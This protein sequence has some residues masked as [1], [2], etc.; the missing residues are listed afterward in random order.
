MLQADM[1]TPKD[2]KEPAQSVFGRR[3]RRYRRTKISGIEC[4]VAAGKSVF[5]GTVEDLSPQGF[6][7]S[8]VPEMFRNEDKI[9]KAIFSKSDSYFR[10]TIIPCWSKPIADSSTFEVGYKIL[11]NDWKW[12]HF[13]MEVLPDHYQD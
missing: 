3:E 1:V 2:K 11:D 10:I 9:Y 7:M 4:Q 8:N 12:V 5:K 6:K 13:S